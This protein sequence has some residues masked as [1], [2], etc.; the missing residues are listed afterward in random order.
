MYFE[1]ETENKLMFI[2]FVV[3]VNY[4]DTDIFSYGMYTMGGKFSLGF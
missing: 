4:T 3:S 2:D 1:G